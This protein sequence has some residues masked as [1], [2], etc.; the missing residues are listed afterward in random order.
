MSTT[1]V[2]STKAP[3][4]RQAPGI[5]WLRVASFVLVMVGLLD[6]IYISY[7]HVAG[8]EVA[9][10]QGAGWNCD[11]VQRSVY[12]MIGPLPVAYLG[13]LGYLA[14]FLVLL[15]EAR[16]PRARIVIFG[17]SLFGLLFSGYL[18]AIEAFVLH[19]WCVWCVLSAITMALFFLVAFGRLWQAIYT[20]PDEEDEAA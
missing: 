6:S 20:V 3:A 18:T 8:Q 11:L 1:V 12:S 4:A 9:C 13:L 5:D 14:I 17:L 15:F 16:I 19:A 10:L 2:N 7:E